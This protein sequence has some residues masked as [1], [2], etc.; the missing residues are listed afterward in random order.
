[1]LKRRRVAFHDRTVLGATAVRETAPMMVEEAR[2]R[3]AEDGFVIVEQLLAPALI[4]GLHDSFEDLFHGRFATGIAPDEVNWQFADG[5]PTLTRQICNGWKADSRI[6]QVV[7]D[8]RFG[9]TLATLGGWSGAR[10]IQDN[11]LWKPPGARPL[12]FHRDNAYST[13]FT[14][15]EM[16]TCWIALDDTTAEGGA[17]EFVRGSHQWPDRGP[18]DIAFHGPEDYR[19]PVRG[20]EHEIVAVEVPTGGGSFHH[21]W[22]WH[23]SGVNATARDR[24]AL[25]IHAAPAEARFDRSRLGEGNGPLYGHFCGENT[26]ELPVE[27]FPVLW[28][29]SPSSSVGTLHR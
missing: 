18:A 17:V 25:V 8:P 2:Q 1:M 29:E 14:P 16:L 12:G 7:L 27:H 5:D 6:A 9:Q 22:T 28:N 10:L 21:G 13:W 24:R 4:A 23:G 26:D 20:H 15:S 3:F 19:R 11:V